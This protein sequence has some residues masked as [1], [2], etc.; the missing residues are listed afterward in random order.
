MWVVTQL[1]FPGGTEGVGVQRTPGAGVGLA[2]SGYSLCSRKEAGPRLYSLL[3][4]SGKIWVLQGM[5]LQEG[6]NGRMP[7]V[8]VVWFSLARFAD[9]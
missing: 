9:A 2:S 1:W 4:P 6:Q 8:S 3:L 5:G 7:L